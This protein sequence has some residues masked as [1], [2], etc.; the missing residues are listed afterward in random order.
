MNQCK[1]TKIDSYYYPFFI[2]VDELITIMKIGVLKEEKFPIDKRVPLTPMQCRILLNTYPKLEIF[3]MKSSI[4]CFSDDMYCKE[5]INV[6]DDLS[7]CDILLG[8]KEVP[9]AS[10][11]ANKTYFYFSH[12]IKEQS[13]NRDLLIKM[14]QLNIRMVDY[15]VLRNKK[16]SRLLGFGKYAGIVGAYNALLTYGLK[17]DKYFLKPAHECLDRVEL[18]LEMNNIRLTNERIIVTGN[19]RVGKGIIELMS[20]SMIKQVSKSEFLNNTFDYPVFVHLNT[21]DYNIKIDGSLSSKNEFYNSP[22]LYKSCFINFVKH[23]DIF[24]AGHYYSAGSP[25]LISKEDTKRSDFNLKVIADISCDINGPIACTIRPSTIDHPIYGYNVLTEEEDDF[26]K[27]NVIAV[28]AVDNLPC[29][30]PKDASQYFGK[31]FISRIFP[32]LLLEDPDEIIKNATICK[33]GDLTSEFEYLRGF[34]NTY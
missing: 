17:V 15:E 21:M 33:N 19:G 31:E 5:G 26:K 30:L 27:S 18:E 14:I 8:V 2:F 4:R 16:G 9:L 22:N 24:I 25:Y 28:M 34:I 6:V 3:I 10:L 12:T 7:N 13:Y 11:I 29:E 20:K 1:T 23:S 32:L